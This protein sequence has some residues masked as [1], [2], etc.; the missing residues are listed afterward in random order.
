MGVNFELTWVF[1][2]FSWQNLGLDIV[3]NNRVAQNNV[4][5]TFVFVNV[6][7]AI[8]NLIYMWSD[9]RIEISSHI[10]STLAEQQIFEFLALFDYCLVLLTG[11]SSTFKTVLHVT[12]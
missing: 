8:I 9:F 1:E 2:H 3:L 6:S 4:L 5:F 12:L 7:Q 11:S 10:N